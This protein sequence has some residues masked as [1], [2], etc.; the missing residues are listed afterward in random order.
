MIA[1]MI[2]VSNVGDGSLLSAGSVD[3][4]DAAPAVGISPGAV[5]VAV[6]GVGEGATA[7]QVG[8]S[9]PSVEIER[10]QVRATVNM[11]RFI[12]I[13]PYLRKNH[14]HMFTSPKIRPMPQHFLQGRAERTN[15]AFAIAQLASL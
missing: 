14:V 8:I 11:N 1:M 13:T 7:P 5:L 3:A 6:A 10:M 15:I 4:G 2:V 9:P 12:G